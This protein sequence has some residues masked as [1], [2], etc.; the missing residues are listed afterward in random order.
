M[1]IF[2]EMQ[3]CKPMRQQ[4]HLTCSAGWMVGCL[5]SHCANLPSL[6]ERRTFASMVEKVDLINAAGLQDEFKSEV[7]RK[8]QPG[9]KTA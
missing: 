4:V 1:R 8:F 9:K 7:Q 5:A 2:P 3:C 6:S